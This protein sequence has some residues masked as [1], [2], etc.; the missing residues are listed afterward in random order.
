MGFYKKLY[1][2]SGLASSARLIQIVAAPALAF[3]FI[4]TPDSLPTFDLCLIHAT[5]GLKCPGCGMTHAFCA[6]S[7]GHFAAAWGLNPLSFHLYL[8][9]VLGLVFP[10]FVSAV[11]ERLVRGIAVSTAAA[12]VAFG[13]WRLCCAIV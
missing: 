8:L 6:I 7:H 9:A 13:A 12:L 10:F 11:P 1:K 2:Q 3:S 4:F 5:T